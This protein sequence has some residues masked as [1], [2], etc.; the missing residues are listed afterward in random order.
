MDA[1]MLNPIFSAND[2]HSGST[3]LCTFIIS[4]PHQSTEAATVVDISAIH[5]TVSITIRCRTTMLTRQPIEKC[6]KCCDRT[7]SIILLRSQSKRIIASH[8]QI[9]KKR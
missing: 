1:Q 2:L 7:P 3:H 5:P 6:F 9:T 8:N 4:V